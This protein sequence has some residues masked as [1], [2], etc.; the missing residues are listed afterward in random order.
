MSFVFLCSPHPK[1]RTTCVDILNS[2]RSIYAAAR[3]AERASYDELIPTRL[4]DIIDE[5]GPDIMSR[6]QHPNNTLMDVRQFRH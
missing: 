4:M 3:E 6:V 2:V 1:I 5:T